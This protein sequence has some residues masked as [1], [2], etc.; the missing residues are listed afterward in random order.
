MLIRKSSATKNVRNPYRRATARSFGGHEDF[1]SYTANAIPRF[2]SGNVSF[3]IA[4]R[5]AANR[6]H[7]RPAKAKVKDGFRVDYIGIGLISLGLGSMQIILDKGQRED[8]LASGL[9]QVFAVLMVVGLISAIFWELRQRPSSGGF[10]DVEN[11]NFAIATTAM[12][13]WASCCIRARS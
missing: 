2:A 7:P 13:S 10:A 12:F 9:I 4:A 5:S 8:W 1:D 3:R 11:R 6:R